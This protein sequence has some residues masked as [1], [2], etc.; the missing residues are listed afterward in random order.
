M[1]K[2]LRLVYYW[3]PPVI[4]MSIIFYLSSRLHAQVTGKFLFD[5]LIFK[6]LHMIEYAILY[7]LL[8]RAFYSISKS[9]LTI[10]HKFLYP[11]LISILYAASDEIHQ[12]FVPTREGKI[13]DVFIDTAGIIMMYIYIKHNISAVK[14]FLN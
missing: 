2:F 11:L 1:R 3:L 10:N 4:W 13:R 8:L 9:Y 12:T 7:F 6:S 5:F 14:K